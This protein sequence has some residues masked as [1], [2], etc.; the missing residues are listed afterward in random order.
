MKKYLLSVLLLFSLGNFSLFAW[1]NSVQ[2]HGMASSTDK[3]WNAVVILED[4]T[5]EESIWAFRSEP[6]WD[7]PIQLKKFKSQGG[8]ATPTV[9]FD[10]ETNSI[11][12]YH[13]CWI[14]QN[15]D[16][17]IYEFPLVNGIYSSSIYKRTPTDNYPIATSKLLSNEHG[18]YIYCTYGE[19]SGKED[20]NAKLFKLIKN[21][22]HFELKSPDS[23][24]DMFF[25]HLDWRHGEKPRDKNSVNVTRGVCFS[26]QNGL[27]LLDIDETTWWY[28]DCSSEKLTKWKSKE[29]A[30][31]YDAK[32]TEKKITDDFIKTKHLKLFIILSAVILF[33]LLAVIILLY[34]KLSNQ[35]KKPVAIDS[36]STKEK[37]RFIFSI[38]EKERSKI[39]R[40]IHDSVVQDIRVIR[41]ETENLKV[42]EE[43]KALQ[44]KIEDI[45]TD[46][47]VKLRNICYNLAPAELTAHSDGDSSEIELV[48]IINSLAQQFS[49]R[50]HVS[51]SVGVEEKF[52]YPSLEK[53]VTQNLFRVIQEAL[54][55]IEKHSYATQTSIFIKNEGT[56][57]VIYVTDD[58]IGADPETI[59]ASLKSKEHL[60]LR[61]MKDRMDLIGG[62]IDFI[63]SQDDGMEIRIELGTGQ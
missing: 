31:D 22:E 41:L 61:S 51:C 24:K 58:G 50:T 16:G 52:S 45:A 20:R 49:A 10:Y 32:L 36:V 39:S 42:Q 17:G 11:I 55:N 5:T 35:K 40:D 44:N 8:W 12:A 63:T 28:F 25:A 19:W 30:F 18:V 13:N 47:I 59:E 33:I 26:A 53:E 60:G 56:A 2:L 46:C 23:T 37:N 14:S 43:S 6:W 62:K 34:I 29:A 4:K 9:C 1:D 27:I 15:N 38:Q 3:E 54:T 7:T 21:G 57:I 48:S